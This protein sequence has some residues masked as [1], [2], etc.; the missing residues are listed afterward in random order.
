MSDMHLSQ[1][2]RFLAVGAF[3]AACYVVGSYTLTIAGLD[4]WLSSCIVYTC[5]IPIIYLIQKSF[6]FKSNLS[7]AKSF[8]R[9]VVIQLIGI[10]ISTI[11][12][13]I[14]SLL[15]I[16]PA[17]SFLVVAVV[18]TFTNYLLQ[19]NWSFATQTNTD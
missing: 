16:G 7:H 3:G 9:Y 8:P 10:C 19:L 2:S 13:Y 18:I 5:L 15:G 12:P 6:A 4:A 17:A 1:F 11:L 14:F